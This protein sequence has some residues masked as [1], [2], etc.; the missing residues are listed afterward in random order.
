MICDC[1]QYT[2]PTID[3]V[4]GETQKFSFTLLTK[5]G[6]TFDASSCTASLSVISHINKNGE[7]IVE[8]DI[9]M[10]MGEGGVMNVA[11]VELLPEETV[12]LSGRYIYQI[13]IRD[14]ID[15]KT[16]IP[17]QGIMNITRNIDR[18]FI[19]RTKTRRCSFRTR[20]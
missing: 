12:C 1:N 17:G 18:G 16:D 4:G 20:P 10:E 8:K 15:N 5:K 14:R 6:K 7:P 2:L 9:I 19:T 13:S 3:F 11:T